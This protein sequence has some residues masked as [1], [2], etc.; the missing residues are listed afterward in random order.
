MNKLL[1]AFLFLAGFARTQTIIQYDNMETSSTTYLTAGWW[2]PAATTG[3]FNNASVTPTLSAVIYGAGNGTSANEQDWYSMPNI[4]GLIT[5]RQYQLKFRLASYTYS[6]PTAATRGLDAAD[7]VEVQVS[8]NGGVSYVSELRIAGNSNAQWPFTATGTITHTANGVFSASLAPA[9]D[10][11]Q[12]TAGVS[13]TGPATVILKLPLGISKVAVDIFCRTNS[14]GEE[15][16]IDNIE[17]WDMTPLG[18]PV[19]MLSLTGEY[20]D[21]VNTID[22]I[23]ASEWNSDYYLI[24][25]SITGE[26][27]EKSVIES[28]PA[29]G[30][31]NTELSYTY[32][33]ATFDP[34]INYYQITQ[35]DK[36]GAFKVYGPILIDNRIARK[37]IVRILDMTGQ[38]VQENTT[39]L[40][41]GLYI[42]IYEDGS[43]QKVYK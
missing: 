35:V 22:W 19:E 41:R 40:M 18:L 28:I 14:A 20:I 4:T 31:S 36:D 23:T 9:G 26:F 17:L 37:R 43:M 5:T 25:R 32:V 13:T 15:W 2:T 38:E 39:N 16:W 33:D 7:I 24:E 11:Y 29:A 42:E 10:V 6:A 3:W 34:G 30:N 21:G 8:T 12:A 27:T 1:V